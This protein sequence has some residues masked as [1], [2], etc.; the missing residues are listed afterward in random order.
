[1]ELCYIYSLCLASV[2][3]YYFLESSTLL[4]VTSPLIFTAVCVTISEF[5]HS[6]V[7]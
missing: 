4:H 2:I 5:V 3:Q 7:D 6:S 1:M